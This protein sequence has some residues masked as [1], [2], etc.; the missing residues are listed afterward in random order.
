MKKDPTDVYLVSFPWLLVRARGQRDK[1][2]LRRGWEDPDFLGR[3][4]KQ[5][6]HLPTLKLLCRQGQGMV[7]STPHLSFCSFLCLQNIL[8]KVRS[9]AKSAKILQIKQHQVS[10]MVRT[11]LWITGSFRYLLLN[12]NQYALKKFL[13][14][15]HLNYFCT[16]EQHCFGYR[17]YGS[18]CWMQHCVVSLLPFNAQTQC[19]SQSL[20][21]S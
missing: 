6:C 12:Q 7:L 15:C 16:Q 10:E 1:A 4:T 21:K 13:L 8:R 17:A 20:L 3:Q 2:L 11:K 5:P 18:N 9:M 19:L 14:P